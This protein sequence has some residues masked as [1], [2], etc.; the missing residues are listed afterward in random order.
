MESEQS[1]LDVVLSTLKE[2]IPN[3]VGPGAVCFYRDPSSGSWKEA[4]FH[5]WI[6]PGYSPQAIVHDKITRKCFLHMMP[7]LRFRK[8]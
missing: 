8:P 5:K 7:D 4:I 2:F 1:S 3:Y 6:E